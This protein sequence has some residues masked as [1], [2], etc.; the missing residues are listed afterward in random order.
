MMLVEWE[1]DPDRGESASTTVWY[2]LDPRKWNKDRAH[3]GWRFHPAELALRA[4]AAREQRE[5]ARE[6]RECATSPDK[7]L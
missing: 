1:P 7:G 6:Q 5:A 4:R 2:L 3:R